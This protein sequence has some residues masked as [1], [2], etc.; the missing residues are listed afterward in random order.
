MGEN[1]LE[2][3]KGALKLV[4]FLS[5]MTSKNESGDVDVVLVNTVATLPY[6]DN[7]V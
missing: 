7:Y 6:V 2:R 4:F 3:V 5:I 1:V